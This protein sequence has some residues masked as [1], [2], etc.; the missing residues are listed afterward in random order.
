MT[1]FIR[2]ILALSFSCHLSMTFLMMLSQGLI[3]NFNLGGGTNLVGFTMVIT[4][5]SDP[6]HAAEGS[7]G[8]LLTNA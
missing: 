3:K 2:P 4:V 5:V 6:R 7:C 8:L 1:G